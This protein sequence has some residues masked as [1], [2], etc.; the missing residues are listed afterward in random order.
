MKKIFIFIYL[1]IFL[2]SCAKDPQVSIPDG[3]WWGEA[4]V[5]KNGGLWIGKPYAVVAK[6]FSD[7]IV[8]NIDSLNNYYLRSKQLYFFNIPILPGIYPI[9]DNIYQ[10]EDSSVVSKYMYVDVDVLYGTYKVLESDS[11]SFITITSYDSVSKELKGTFDVT[12]VK[13]ISPGP[14]APDTIRFRNGVFHTKVIK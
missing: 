12:F 14:N 8:I 10:E 2:I 6:K 7:K 1:A 9:F 5:Q 3:P 13:E 11:S 4:S